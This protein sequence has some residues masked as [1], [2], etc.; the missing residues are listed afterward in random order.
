[1]SPAT[2]RRPCGVAALLFA[3]VLVAA[4]PAVPA[5]E[6]AEARRERALADMQS[7]DAGL[8]E[9]AIA[10]LGETG[11]EPDLPRLLGALRDAAE[12]V[13]HA[14]ERA[15]WRIWGR[16]G[17]AETDRVFGIG[18]SQMEAGDLRD[19]VQTFGRVIA[20]KPEFAEGWNKRATVYFLLG[21]LERSL[22]DCDEV[23]K[24]NPVHFGVLAGYG[25][26]HVQQGNLDAALDYFERAL[27]IN[28]NMDGV[29]A[30]VEAIGQV[31]SRK[32]RQTI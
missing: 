21:D 28:P 20:M 29:R 30:S 18:L 25:Q 8:R 26:I 19:A 3:A 6:P 7:P 32:R 13:R 2:L 4:T 15:I 22:R 14:A 27:D 16:S 5:E 9:K 11:R 1:M 31:L 23:I 12:E 24:R 17:D 10:V